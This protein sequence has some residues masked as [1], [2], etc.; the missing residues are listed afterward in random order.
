MKEILHI[1]LIFCLLSNLSAQQ[2]S[3]ANQLLKAG[4]EKL[5]YQDFT[6]AIKDFNKASRMNTSLYEAYNGRAEAKLNLSQ[7]DEALRDINKSMEIRNDAPQ[8]YLLRGRIYAAQKKNTEALADLNKALELKSDF[9]EAISQ[10]A[11]FILPNSE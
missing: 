11:M 3:D 8:S 4:S 1:V 6:G 7:L 2:Q 10:K 5:K 9:Y